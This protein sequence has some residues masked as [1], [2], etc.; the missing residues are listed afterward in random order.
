MTANFFLIFL[1]QK[2][3][4]T[5]AMKDVYFSYSTRPDVQVLRGFSLTV[6][7]GETVALVGLSGC[8]KSTIMMLLERFYEP[9]SGTIVS[10]SFS[11]ICSTSLVD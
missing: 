8:G 1:F 9:Q 10:F 4:G 6:K 2:I 5:I 11:F 3:Q 7:Q